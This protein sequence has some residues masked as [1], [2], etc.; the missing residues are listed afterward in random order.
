MSWAH[1]F[2]SRDAPA[3]SLAPIVADRV[4]ALIRAVVATEPA[5][6]LEY[7]AV[8]AGDSFRRIDRIDRVN[9]EVVV[10]LAAR[11]GATRLL[12]NFRLRPKEIES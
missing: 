7:A 2:C 3:T 12:D 8:V 1:S 10:P 5:V 4:F 11:V 9:G 6:E